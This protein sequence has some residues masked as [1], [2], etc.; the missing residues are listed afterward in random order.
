MDVIPDG[1]T[2]A[3][4]GTG[5]VLEPDLLLS[6]LESR[7]LA[8]SGPTGLRVVALMCTGD[9]TGRGGLN[10]I[11][12]SGMVK[13]VVASSMYAHRHPG[14]TEMLRSGEI[15]GYIVG[16]G[17]LVQM[18][19][20][21]A[22]GKPG[23]LT[24]AGLGT[25]LDPRIE[26]GRMNAK[27][28]EPPVRLLEIDGNEYLFY[29]ALPIDVALIRATTA[30]EDGYL[31]FEEEPNTLGVLEIAAATKASGGQVIVQVKNL[32]SAGSLD[33]RRVG[34]PGTLVDR[35]VVHPEQTQLGPTMHD[36]AR[37]WNP[38][39]VGALRM[40]PGHGLTVA[41]P[42]DRIILCRAA[43][44]LAPGAVVNVGAGLPTKLPMMLDELGSLDE[45]TIT[46]EHGV[47]GGLLGTS[48]GGSFVPGVN[49][50]AIMDSVFQFNYYE[51]GG[52]DIAF[53]GAGQVD[54]LGNVNVSKFA[55][56]WNGPGGLCSITHS[57]K[58]IVY[59]TSLTSGGL[60]VRVVDGRLEVVREGA[61]KT[62][63]PEVEQVTF[64]AKLA[65]SRGQTVVYVTERCVFELD[66]QGLLVTELAPGVDVGLHIQPHVGFPVRV[67]ADV[68]T[69]SFGLHQEH[70]SLAEVTL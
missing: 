9:Q 4:C 55:N 54:S 34:V 14:M 64:N 57:T 69:M 22:S 23:V 29:E 11:A 7:F 12:H 56:H 65:H 44:E 25:F 60:S 48:L 66:H 43:D 10:H 38:Y 62:F 32:V 46:N 59:C 68:K 51:G 13:S 28:T 41:D 37:G 47:F 61:H 58:K 1:A 2:V 20:A 26:G 39:L 63:V 31:S 67:S 53:L 21:T 15:E 8:S 49:P 35:I 33:P 18:L 24:Q 36:A 3:I 6:S 42:K 19:T 17:S 16:M 45:V 50:K 30:D 70:P 52:L 27:S 5:V 40:A